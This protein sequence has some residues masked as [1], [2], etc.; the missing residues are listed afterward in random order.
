MPLEAS[1][2]V[3]ASMYINHDDIPDVIK[4]FVMLDFNKHF[5]NL[6][7]RILIHDTLCFATYEWCHPY[8]YLFRAE[9]LMMNKP[10]FIYEHRNNYFSIQP[11]KK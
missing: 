10:S 2:N 7:V 4:G 3:A 6:L 11:L 9:S 8:F 5:Y 1:R